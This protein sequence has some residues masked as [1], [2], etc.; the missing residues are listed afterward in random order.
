MGE[1]TGA[2]KGGGQKTSQKGRERVPPGTTHEKALCLLVQ[3][4][5]QDQNPDP[6]AGILW[7]SERPRDLYQVP[8][9]DLQQG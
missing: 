9:R 6:D 3:M 2:G 5:I 8:R 7:H 4:Q 1:G